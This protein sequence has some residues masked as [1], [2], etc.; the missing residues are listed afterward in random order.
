MGINT[1]KKNRVDQTSSDQAL[2][3]GLNKHEAAIPAVVIAGVTVATKALVTTVQSRIDSSKAVLSKRAAWQAAIQDDRALRD[4]TK[5]FVAG[6]KQ[7]LLVAFAGQIDALAA[8]G[9]T[10]RKVPVATPEQRIAATAKALATRAARHTMGSKQKADVKGTVA[11]AAP[12]SPTVPAPTPAPTPTVAPI[13]AEPA[14]PVAQPVTAPA[15]TMPATQPAASAPV[16]VA[17]PAAAPIAAPVPVAPVASPIAVPPVTAP[18]P[19]AA[20]AAPAVTP[21]APAT[22]THL[23]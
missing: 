2:I 7:A 6:L 22:P 4:K 16:A 3:D 19:A 10:A 17:T 5:T 20:P 8:F 21:A 9:L 12:A 11:P 15:P 1:P 13:V 23:A 14:L 18:A